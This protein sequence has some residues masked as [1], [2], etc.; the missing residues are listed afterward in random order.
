MIT[1]VHGKIFYSPARALINPVN[2]MGV[3]SSGLAYDFKRFF[4][5]MYDAYR[6]LCHNDNL[7]IGQL[8]LY[9]T[10]HKLIVNFPTR[11]SNRAAEN[12]EYIEEGLKKF[13]QVY[14]HHGI[15]SA[16]FPAFGTEDDD[17]AWD[18]MRPIME[19]YLDPLPIS[20]Y[21]HLAP[22]DTIVSDTAIGGSTR[23]MRHWLNAQPHNMPFEAFWQDCLAV[24]KARNEFA[25]FKTGKRI[26]AVA[27]QAKGR[28]RLSLKLSP[29][30]GE[31][32]YLTESQLRDIWQYIKRVGY[33]IPQ[34]LPSM[35]NTTY[36]NDGNELPAHSVVAFLAQLPYITPVRL[37]VN[38]DET[39]IGLHY[40]PPIEQTPNVMSIDLAE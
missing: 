27:T 23:T 36:G 39:S 28:Q 26:T 21:I 30:Y 22:D 12:I 10:S 2:T 6:D 31:S 9:R 8:M 17:I 24:V 40:V 16:S 25:S 7:G 13:V 33:V 35:G 14:A 15:T 29:K 37:G 5:E 11:K 3:M 32:L 19:A 18:D 34:N 4:P 1:Y 38:V 20:I